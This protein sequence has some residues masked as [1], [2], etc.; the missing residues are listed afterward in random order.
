MCL[1]S[2]KSFFFVWF[3]KLP[4]SS[5]AIV[6]IVGNFFGKSRRDL[7]TMFGKIS[8][9]GLQSSENSRKLLIN[10]CLFIINEIIYT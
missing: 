3:F 8:R 7:Q 6:A 9:N 5:S 10:R 4:Q 1:K 2:T